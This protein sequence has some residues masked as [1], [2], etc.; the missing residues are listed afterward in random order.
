MNE[1]E[2]KNF[3]AYLLTLT[4]SER[5]EAIAHVQKKGNELLEIVTTIKWKLEQQKEMRI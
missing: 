5:E 2:Y 3:I 4:Q 1:T